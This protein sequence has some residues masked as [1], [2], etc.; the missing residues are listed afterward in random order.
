MLKMDYLLLYIDPGTGSM[1]L[2]LL[3]SA[4]SVIFYF[5]TDIFNRLMILLSGGRGR[6][7]GEISPMVIF[8]DHKR[9]WNVFEPICD[10]FE[11]REEDVLYLTA[12]PDDPVFRKEYKHVRAEYIG[13]GNRAFARLNT[14]KAKVLLSTTPNLDVF[15]WKRSKGV[16][17]YVHIAHAADDITKYRMFGIDYYD[18]ILLSG[19][20]QGKQVRALEKIRNLPEKDIEYV[21]V[22]YFDKMKQRLDECPRV[23]RDMQGKDG[24]TVL[25]APSWGK[26]GILSKCGEEF[27]DS[28]AE[29]GYRII[30]RPHPQSYVAEKDLIE[31]LQK[32][33]Q[34]VQN[35]SW[36]QDNDNFEALKNSDIL[37]SDFSG[38]I[39]DYALVFDKPVIYADTDFDKSPYDCYWLDDELWTFKILPAFGKELKQT[40][41]KEIG[42]MIGDC[43]SDGSYEAGREQ[44]RKD[45]WMHMG[46]G[47]KRT[48]D[49][50]EKCISDPGKN[51]TNG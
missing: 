49:Y 24:I 11:N 21:G 8:S 42:R 46:E 40:D 48:V 32:K 45:T 10:E 38:V 47:A 34:G 9:Y 1:L 22:P 35:I 28:L 3:I 7:T 19:E 16:E 39:F 27:I 12:S 36:N 29:T 33:Y 30:I 20:Y 15:Q 17:R 37:I 23:K 5:F 2:A 50:L 51:G 26:N 13:S 6:Q 43:L 4:L 18:S 44:A 41:V 25:L 14:L 31:K